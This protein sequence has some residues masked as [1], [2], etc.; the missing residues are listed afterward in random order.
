M[1]KE[2][3]RQAV[4]SLLPAVI[5]LSALEPALPTMYSSPPRVLPVELMR[6]GD[7]AFVS[8]DDDEARWEVLAA[9]V[10]EGL[11]RGEKV[12]VL[13][14]PKLSEEEIRARITTDTTDWATR[15]DPAQ[16]KYTSM[17]ELIAPHTEFTAQRQVSRLWEET[18]RAGLEGYSGLRTVIDMGWVQDLG[19]DVTAVVHRETHA[20]ALFKNRRYAEICAYDRRRF[21]P[22]VIEAMRQGHPVS[23][24]ERLGG[25]SC[26]HGVTA[27]RMAGDAD[28]VNRAPFTDA[29]RT[30]LTTNA[31]A[32]RV[33]LDLTDLCFLDVGCATG[34]L[35]MIASGSGRTHVEIHCSAFHASLLRRLGA[36]AVEQ[37]A[38]VETARS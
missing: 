7:H 21:A 30:C 35:R 11:R 8:Y 12:S 29:V 3:Q 23:L 36:D 16:L 9:F 31:A 26:V 17:R 2:P 25:L 27:L 22:A 37:L 20:D 14:D 4:A 28:L 32:P 5:S 18:R 33:L 24:V 38:L 1:R 13:A 6:P 10:Q 15:N 34:L 19:T